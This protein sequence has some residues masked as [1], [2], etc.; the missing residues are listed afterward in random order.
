MEIAEEIAA[1]TTTEIKMEDVAE[2]VT[3]TRTTDTPVPEMTLNEVKALIKLRI[4]NSPGNSNGPPSAFWLFQFLPTELRRQ[5]W[6]MVVSMPITDSKEPCIKVKAIIKMCGMSAGEYYKD[7]SRWDSNDDVK[8]SFALSNKL[9]LRSDWRHPSTEMNAGIFDTAKII[10]VCRESR[11]AAVE[12]FTDILALWVRLVLYASART[13]LLSPSSI[14]RIWC[15][16]F[17]LHRS[18]CHLRSQRF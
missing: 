8:L 7:D 18:Q 12:T 17:L 3:A 4:K 16:A 13:R 2:T 5:I 11:A 1:D 9:Y 6:N 15:G 10:T 14:F